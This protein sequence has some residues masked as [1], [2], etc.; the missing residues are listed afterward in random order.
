MAVNL[1]DAKFLI[2]EDEEDKSDLFFRMLLEQNVSE[3][4]IEVSET[5]DSA[6]EKISE[7]EPEII[8]LDV[9][10]PRDESSQPES[11]NCIDVIN[12]VK[13][14][15]H[16][17]TGK[18]RIILIS[19]TVKDKGIQKIIQSE[20]K[21]FVDFLDKTEIATN[22]DKFKEKLL[23]DIKKALKNDE[24]EEKIDYSFVRKSNLK[25][26]KKLKPPL[27]KKIEEEILNEFEKLNNKNVN[28]HLVSKNI[29]RNCGEIV[30]VITYY[31]EDN[32]INLNDIVI[33]NNPNSIRNRLTIL[34]GRAYKSNEEGYEVVS[35]K[36]LISRKACE[37]GYRAYL[38]RNQASHAAEV[39]EQNRNIF[40]QTRLN[41]EDAAIS[42]S[43]IMP[44]MNDYIAFL[45]NKE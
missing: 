40:N 25:E 7:F 32:T 36:T 42:L 22:L 24:E 33:S 8:L 14:Y 9:K 19:A 23:K 12:A 37:F 18:I 35:K 5:S 26:L 3:D 38:L 11:D 2:V 21:I 44:L 15:N 17:N 4:Q 34:T 13:L 1:Q 28:E 20:K 30:E 43:L 16:E 29:I 10:I 6:K 41:K 39:D 27:W 45:K 31:L